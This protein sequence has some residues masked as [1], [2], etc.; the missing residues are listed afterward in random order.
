MEN[1][2]FFH[3][4]NITVHDLSNAIA[5]YLYKLYLFYFMKK[6]AI[7]TGGN[8]SEQDIA[9]ASAQSVAEALKNQYEITVFDIPR[10]MD[11]F[12]ATRRAFEVAIPVLHGRGGEDGEI[13]GFLKTLGI[14][15]I[16]SDVTAHA[17]GIDKSLTKKIVSLASVPTPNS[18]TL[19]QSDSLPAWSGSVVVKPLDGG[20]TIGVSIVKQESDLPAALQLAFEQS[21]SVLIEQFVAGN[22]FSIA[23]I[24]ENKKT[25][26]LPVIAIKPKSGFFDFEAKYTPGMAVEDCPAQI[27]EAL[28]SKLQA[29]AVT[30]HLAIGAH[31]VSR[32]DFIVDAN[33][34]QWFLEINTI[35]GMS[36]LLPKAIRA[37]GRDF[38]ATL[39]G[40]IEEV[41]AD[42]VQK[43]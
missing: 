38:G 4:T 3:Y 22:E 42:R 29:L 14:P 2:G 25:V 36:V 28:S 21:S 18:Q 26:A 19:K 8:S 30:A 37:S 17:I 32:S 13:Q 24:D 12:L 15:F 31:H 9:R 41:L 11:Q 27:P 6:I 1:H 40:W 5:L 7:I 43:Q 34:K 33:G 10:D 35:P 16:F 23:V 39:A 20:S